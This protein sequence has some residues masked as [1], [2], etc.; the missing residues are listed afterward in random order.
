MGPVSGVAGGGLLT[1][2]VLR[3][4]DPSPPA[5]GSRGSRLGQEAT[6][7]ALCRMRKYMPDLQQGEIAEKCELLCGQGE[8]VS[9]KKITLA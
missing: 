4:E 1:S 8:P 9:R 3:A 2:S 7:R 5:R 6:C